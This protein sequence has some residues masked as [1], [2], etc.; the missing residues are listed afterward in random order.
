[1]DTPGQDVDAQSAQLI[2]EFT[3]HVDEFLALHPEEADR[4]DE[5]F[6]AWVIQKLAGIQ[7]SIMEIAN[8]LN[9]FTQRYDHEKGNP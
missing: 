6:Q 1:M 8:R 9:A 4:R 7:L 2:Q 3:D 5:I